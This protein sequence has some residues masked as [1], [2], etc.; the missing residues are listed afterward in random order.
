MKNKEMPLVGPHIRTCLTIPRVMLDVILALVPVMALAIVFFGPGAL[1]VM[2]LA[3]IS[4]CLTEWVII[5]RRMSP[6]A[7]WGDGSAAVTGLLLGMTLSP[8]APWWIPVLGGFLAIAV[9]KQLF[10][11]LGRN[12]F[13]PALVARA[14]LLL[15]WTG[16]NVHFAVPYEGTTGATPL[17]TGAAGLWDLAMGAVPGAIGETSAIAILVGGA[18]LLY[19]GHIDWRIPSGVIAGAFVASWMM[20]T[21][22]LYGILAGGLMLAAVF[23]ATDMVTSPVTRMGR[24]LFGVV[25]GGLTIVI[26]HYS[27]FPEGVTFAVL[28]GNALVP[29]IDRHTMGL[30]FGEAPSSKPLQAAVTAVL[31]TA[32]AGGALL[33]VA[34]LGQEL[35]QERA[36]LAMASTLV[37][38]LPAA[39]TFEER[40]IE[41]RQV[42]IGLAGGQ[43][44]GAVLFWSERGFN[45]P[46]TLLIGI[47]TT[48]E[49]TGVVVIDHDEDPGLG[50]RVT[51]SG[52]LPQ[53]VGKTRDHDIALGRDVESITGA[54]ISSRTVA[55]AI[56]N[57][58]SFHAAAILGMGDDDEFDLSRVVD[59]VYTGSAEGFMGPVTVE[60]TVAGGRIES[61][62][63]KSHSDTPNIAGPAFEELSGLIVAEQSLAV[64][65]VSGATVSSQALVDAVRN[66][67]SNGDDEAREPD[68]IDIGAL[69]DGEYQGTG[70]G[71]MGPI[72]VRVTVSGGRLESVSVARHEETPD[73]ANPAFKTLTENM[74]NAQS[75]AVDAVSGATASSDGLM[76]AVRDALSGLPTVPVEPID[77]GSIPDG[78]YVGT[79]DGFM[80]DIEVRVTVEGGRITGVVVTRHEDTP[81]IAGPAFE[82]LIDRILSDQSPDVDGVSGATVSSSGLIDAVRNAL[83]G[84][85]Q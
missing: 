1:L 76:G 22:P 30:R 66:A 29:L 69:P 2:A 19:R 5:S 77:I 25:V 39:E 12:V 79:A 42:F 68:I 47:D 10:G 65:A 78:D 8:L 27:V 21:D 74:I 64:D 9:G 70:E 38:V 54:T 75:V 13:N 37:Q 56:R 48:G 50:S 17:F 52:F 49:V 26:R 35:G 11:G 82:T 23:M 14:I 36:Q 55:S 4:S 85:E 81:S 7:L 16:P 58:L 41:G 43:E 15:G 53:F 73:I 18:Y 28:A 80:A 60:V 32:L 34:A 51:E 83:L 44:V 6:T 40:E 84:S 62:V 67:L 31:V 3:T 33:G 20:G 71:F 63:V 45:G 57:A 61:I 72:D 46:V 24:I 59:G